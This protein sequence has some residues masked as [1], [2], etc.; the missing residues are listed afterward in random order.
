MPFFLELLTYDGKIDDAKGEEY[1]KVKPEKVFKTMEEFSKP[2]YDVT[3]L[4]VEMPFNIKFVE[5]Y[6]GDNNVVYTQEEAKKLL[7]KQSDLTDLP[8]IFLSAGV[9]SEEFIAEIKMAEEAGADFNGVLCGRATWKP[10]IK[11][12]AAEGEK[13]GIGTEQSHERYNILMERLEESPEMRMD[14]VRNALDSVSKD[15]FGEFES[16]EWSIVMNLSAREARYYH[17]ENYEQDYTFR[18]GE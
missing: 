7:K 2:Q 12:F 14:A 17:R 4:K 9:T 11:P 10:A 1:A 16:T 18:L 6:N 15:N 5:G 8:Y 13:Q 3:V